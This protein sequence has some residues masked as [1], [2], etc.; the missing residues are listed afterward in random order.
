MVAEANSFA[1]AYDSSFTVKRALRNS[2]KRNSFLQM[3]TDSNR[4]GLGMFLKVP[5]PYLLRDDVL[6]YGAIH[7]RR[8]TGRT[9]SS[10]A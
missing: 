8:H 3:L 7:L 1:E 2:L 4:I 10:S 5:S 6:E 9:G